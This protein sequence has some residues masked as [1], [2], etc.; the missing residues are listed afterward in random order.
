MA[1]KLRVLISG[2]SSGFGADA[3]RALASNGHTVFATM[4][5]VR[6]KNE[7]K[8]KE[9]TQWAKSNGAAL[10]VLDLDVTDDASVSAAVSAAVEQAGGIDVLVNNAGQ[11]TW[12]ISEAYSAEQFQQLF[13]TNLFGMVRLDRAVLPHMRKAGKGYLIYVSSGLGRILLPFMAPYQASKFAVEAYA[14][15]TSYELAALGIETTI[16]QPGAYGTTFLGNS[17]QP[18]QPALLEQYGPTK[19]AFQA[20]SKAF[21]ERHAAGQL[22]QPHEIR[23][24]I[25]AL[26]ETPPGKR[27]LRRTVGADIAEPVGAINK[28]CADV[29][30]QLLRRFGMRQ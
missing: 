20:F 18:G 4:R 3:A 25:V 28:T 2:S 16:L 29:Q 15:T 10:T 11:G 13:A 9:L 26:V 14:E 1:D 6:G 30:D 5:A 24:A 22:G 19:A 7:G 23:D 27:P 21:E 8:A 17:M 12:G